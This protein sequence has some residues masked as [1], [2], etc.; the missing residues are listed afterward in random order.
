MKEEIRNT[1]E[2]LKGIR[3][4]VVMEIQVNEIR[5]MGEGRPRNDDQRMA[6]AVE[7]NNVGERR[8]GRAAALGGRWN[9]K[10]SRGGGSVSNIICNSLVCFKFT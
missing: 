8:S 9:L 4:T 5:E 2:S 6:E 7:R 3:K 10:G 1:G